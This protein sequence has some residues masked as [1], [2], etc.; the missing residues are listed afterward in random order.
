MVLQLPGHGPDRLGRPRKLLGQGL[1]GRVVPGRRPHLLRRQG[2]EVLGFPLREEGEGPGEPFPD[3][4]QV[5]EAL[6]QGQKLLLLP[7][8]HPGLLNLPDLVAEEVLPLRPGL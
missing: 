6:R 4:L 2:Q 8:P 3:G 7:G 1:E 5:A